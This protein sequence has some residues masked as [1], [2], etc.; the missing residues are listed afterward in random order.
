MFYIHRISKPNTPYGIITLENA[1]ITGG[2]YL[3][4]HMLYESLMGTIHTLVLPSLLTKGKNLPFTN[5]ACQLVYYMHNALVINDSSNKEH[6]L[7]ISTLDG[8]CCKGALMAAPRT[9][10]FLSFTYFYLLSI[11][12]LV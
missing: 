1:V 5:F 7:N 8:A 4:T 9:L 3:S 6:F 10:F 11:F 2:F 12:N